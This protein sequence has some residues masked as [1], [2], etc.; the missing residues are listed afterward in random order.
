MHNDDIFVSIIDDTMEQYLFSADIDFNIEVALF[1]KPRILDADCAGM[2]AKVRDALGRHP[3]RKAIHGP[4][5]DLA[6]DSSDPKIVAVARERIMQGITIA[7]DISA[8]VMVAHSTFNPLF[9]ASPNYE[10]SWVAKSIAFWRELVTYAQ[11]KN[12]IIVLENIFDDTPVLINDVIR[13][14]D[15]PY[16]KACIDTGHLNIFSHTQIPVWIDTYQDQLHYVHVHNN[17]GTIDEHNAVSD[18]TFDFETFFSCL[19]RY[20]I[21]PILT[22]E[23]RRIADVAPSQQALRTLLNI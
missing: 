21:S 22:L 9:R 3:I 17:Y 14:V 20:G 4:V 15:S 19:Q 7:S 13:G 2:V 10:Q 1:A 23:L 6:Y 16:F 18:G 8:E 5:K 11:A 12:V